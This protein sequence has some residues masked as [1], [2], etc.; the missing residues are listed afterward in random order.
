MVVGWATVAL[1]DVCRRLMAMGWRG[2]EVCLLAGEE[3][4]LV[5]GLEQPAAAHGHRSAPAL[6]LIAATSSSSS[7]GFTR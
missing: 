2:V 4:C 7:T 3:I 5:A 6:R 1:G